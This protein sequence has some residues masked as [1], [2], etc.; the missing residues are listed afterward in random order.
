[1]YQLTGRC[2]MVVQYLLMHDAP[3]TAEQLARSFGVSTRTIRYDLEEIEEF[4]KTKE[5]VL[6]KKSKVG[7]W[8]ENRLQAKEALEINIDDTG[9]YYS[10]V[11]SEKER[12]S[13]ILSTLLESQDYLTFQALAGRANVSRSTII[14]DFV[15][16]EKWLNKRNIQ[17]S[18][19]AKLGV[20]IACSEKE[21]R[22]AIID[23]I[24]ENFDNDSIIRFL[25]ENV[26]K[27]WQ[28]NRIDLFKQRYINSLFNE[29]EQIA[30]EGYFKNI[31][32]ELG[33]K[34]SDAA[35]AGLMIHFGIAV[36]RLNRGK[37]IFMPHA[38]LEALKLKREYKAA[39]KYASE[40][41]NEFKVD[42]P[43]SELGYI[44]LHL[45]GAKIRDEYK[46]DTTEE[47][48][49]DIEV[50]L[51]KEFIDE[52]GYLLGVDL[53]QDEDLKRNLLIH[54]KPSI[55]RIRYDMDIYNPILKDIMDNYTNIF[56]ATKKAAQELYSTLELK[57]NDDEIGFLT[58][59]IGAAI[60]RT[61]EARKENVYRA[62]LVCASG[63]GTAKMLSSRLESEFTQIEIVGEV[64]LDELPEYVD[65]SIDIVIS[66]LPI[67]DMIIKP[68]V[69]VSPLL[70]GR[71]ILSIKSAI[72]ELKEI[73]TSTPKFVSEGLLKLIRKHCTINDEKGLVD[74]ID[75][76]FNCRYINTDLKEGQ[77]LLSEM[78]CTKRMQLNIDLD[79]KEQAIEATGR[80]LVNG[81]CAEERYIE[82]MKRLCKEFNNY[83]VI[84]PGIAMPHARPEDGAINAGFSLI[85][86]KHG[87][88]FGHAKNDPVRLIIGLA[89]TDNKTHLKALSELSM[90][91]DSKE[92]I[93]KLLEATEAEDAIR[94]IKEFEAR[95]LGMVAQ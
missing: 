26:H 90:L 95:I 80:L 30:F 58:M 62:L 56:N 15:D 59:H 4:L 36:K 10:Q 16:V 82:A 60:E 87:I 6:N 47:V 5:V 13:V 7:I 70:T 40:L 44:T 27:K 81:G 73:N 23:Y 33:V 85:T 2:Y 52:V 53:N 49:E 66:T 28:N 31:E 35:F 32:G 63:I 9:D 74:S 8:I 25:K 34:F 19:K 54:I 94:I 78:L 76:Y 83:I 67:D 24:Y 51:V 72:K 45:I 88:V 14:K 37:V 71:D 1:M 75:N 46:K 21:W 89:A 57:V 42:I 3:V 68:V 91:L 86:L 77:K 61:K 12:K 69:C 17:V 48:D 39:Q 11:L 29:N 65:D 92:S 22:K 41:E 55:N 64:P 18:K 38:Q 43:D 20:K 84:A 79:S 50:G 93:N